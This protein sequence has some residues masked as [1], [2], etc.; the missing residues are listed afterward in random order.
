MFDQES[1]VER[2]VLTP[3]ERALMVEQAEAIKVALNTFI[4]HCKDGTPAQVVKS[5]LP[6]V[7]A[8]EYTTSIINTKVGHVYAQVHDEEH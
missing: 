2:I 1:A 7:R 6:V 8:N 3:A 5:Y 4:T